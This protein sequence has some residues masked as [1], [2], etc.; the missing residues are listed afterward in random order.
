MQ[1]W[2]ES[3][4]EQ[5]VRILIKLCI[6]QINYG[7]FFQ[8]SPLENRMFAGI[9]G[10][11]LSLTVGLFVRRYFNHKDCNIENSNKKQKL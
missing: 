9:S 6:V 4:R 11:I 2:W 8:N 3:L 5:I 10:I 1:T 7:I